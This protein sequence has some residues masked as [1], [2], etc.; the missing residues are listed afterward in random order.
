MATQTDSN[1]I[2]LIEATIAYRNRLIQRGQQSGNRDLVTLGNAVIQIDRWLLE[3]ADKPV[4][5]DR[6]VR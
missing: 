4:S 5:Q 3:Y 1:V 6:R 2:P